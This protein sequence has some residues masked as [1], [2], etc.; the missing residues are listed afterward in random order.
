ML[1][2]LEQ[3]F[4]KGEDARM[5]KDEELSKVRSALTKSEEYIEQNGDRF[6]RLVSSIEELNAKMNTFSTL[7]AEIAKNDSK[8]N[9]LVNEF[10]SISEGLNRVKQSANTCATENKEF[11]ASSYAAMRV[12]R[13]TLGRGSRAPPV[14][15]SIVSSAAASVPITLGGNRSTP[16]PPPPSLKFTPAPQQQ[17]RINPATALL[18]Q[19]RGGA[20]LKKV[21]PNEAKAASNRGNWRKSVNM[22]KSLQETLAAALESRRE[23]LLEDEEEE[24]ED[25]WADF[26]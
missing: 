13:S 7:L 10:T 15:P 26:D 9:V 11:L 25:I 6:E 2:V 16:P 17:P 3:E 23:D 20:Q 22:L 24:E 5:K 8:G 21:D 12:R 4:A 1:Q 19:I 14:N 18:A